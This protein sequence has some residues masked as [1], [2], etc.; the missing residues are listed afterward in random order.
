MRLNEL[1]TNIK[2]KIPIILKINDI[3]IDAVTFR[4]TKLNILSSEE[5]TK[6][7]KTY[8]NAIVTNVGIA[9]EASEPHILIEAET[10]MGRWT[11]KE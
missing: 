2:V 10:T 11:E 1:L 9:E 3:E 5:Y 4:G 6:G 8:G 7:K